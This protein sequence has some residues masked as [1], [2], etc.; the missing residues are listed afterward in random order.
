MIVLYTLRSW[1]IRI[2]TKDEVNEEREKFAAEFDVTAFDS[3]QLFSSDFFIPELT[4]SVPHPKNDD[5]PKSELFLRK[6][7]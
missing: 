6:G 7:D 2:K 1:N 5:P 4:N 3:E